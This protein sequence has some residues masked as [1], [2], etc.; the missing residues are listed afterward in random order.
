MAV[1]SHA[2]SSPGSAP[3]VGVVLVTVV[4]VTVVLVTA[5]MLLGC[6]RRRG[7]LLT[8]TAALGIIRTERDLNDRANA[9]LDVD[10]QDRHETGAAARIDDDAFRRLLVAGKTAVPGAVQTNG[11]R[12]FVPR[13]SDY[14]AEF[15]GQWTE[16]G[17]DGTHG[18]T[19]GLFVRLAPGDAWR[20]TLYVYAPSDSPDPLPEL[21]VDRDGYAV[22]LSVGQ[23]QKLRT[24]ADDITRG[25]AEYWNGY[26]DPTFPL[27]T[28]LAAGGWTTQRNENTRQD[29]AKK[30]REQQTERFSASAG[31]YRYGTAY[32]TRSGDALLFIS[33]VEHIAV[34][35]VPP[36]SFSTAM[37]YRGRQVL[38]LSVTQG[39]HEMF[40]DVLYTTAVVEPP[41]GRP[42]RLIAGYS[43]PIGAA[44]VG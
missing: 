19:L 34:S 24:S 8:P 12:A 35:V 1:T 10:L 32:R 38:P 18:T 43:G 6:G 44:R 17:A 36:M 5:A 16:T 20:V 11:S 27:S 31:P 22:R 40:V 3:R 30:A 15:L 41:A 29:V 7:P 33:L 37:T 25:L 39:A 14:P 21:A 4:L 26:A 28:P 23:T 42:V 2:S 13:Q 9:T